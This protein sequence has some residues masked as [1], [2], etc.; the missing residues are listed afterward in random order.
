MSASVVATILQVEC[1]FTDGMT[2]EEIL[3]EAMSKGKNHWMAASENIAFD[4]VVVVSYLNMNAKDKVRLKA[5]TDTMKAMDALLS[6]VPVNMETAL[7]RVEGME[8][9]PLRKMWEEAKP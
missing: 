8:L 6:G 1:N 7:E 3:K 4:A 5:T 2:A 9:F